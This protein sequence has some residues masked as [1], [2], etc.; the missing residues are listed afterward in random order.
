MRKIT[1]YG[2]SLLPAVILLFLFSCKPEAGNPVAENA[3]NKAATSP[4]KQAK[5]FQLTAEFRSYWFAGLAEITSYELEQARYGEQREGDAVLIY[6]TE[7]FLK[8]KQV[9]ADGNN[10]SNISVLKLNSTKKF[11]T[12]IYPYSIM[13]STFYPLDGQEHALKVTNSVQEWC[14]QVFAQINNREQYEVSAYSYFESEGDQELKLDKDVLEN[15]IWTQLR[16]DPESLPTGEILV[17]PALE[18]LRLAHRELKAYPANASRTKNGEFMVYVLEYP[19]L[20]RTLKITYNPDF[21]YEIEG[22]SETYKSGFGD[23]AKMMTS[24]AK[25]INTMKIP[26]WQRNRNKDVILRDSLGLK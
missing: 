15:E 12:G 24:S 19:E 13:T 20:Q 16:V 9:K 26:Y 23:A 6:V 10:P 8:D 22:W 3:G 7:P 2:I 18:Y 21:P 11:V 25:K 14:G 5:A 17:I 1:S 4:E